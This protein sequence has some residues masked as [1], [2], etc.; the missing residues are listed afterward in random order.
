VF[1]IEKKLVVLFAISLLH[2]HTDGVCVPI[3]SVAFST[4]V[5]SMLQFLCCILILAV[6]E[7]SKVANKQLKQL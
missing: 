4:L 5:V 1:A 3:F 2:S 7:S 6:F